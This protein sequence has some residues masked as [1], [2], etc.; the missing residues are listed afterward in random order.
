M[1]KTIDQMVFSYYVA[2]IIY[3]KREGGEIVTKDDYLFM[4]TWALEGVDDERTQKLYKRAIE[5]SRKNV[6]IVAMLKVALEHMFEYDFKDNKSVSSNQVDNK[7]IRNASAI[8]FEKL[9]QVNLLDHT[10]N[11]LEAILQK[12]EEREIYGV[13]QILVA[14]LTHDFGKAK[15]VR[16]LLTPEGVSESSSRYRPH[17]EV[18]GLYVENIL[19]EEAK[20]LLLTKDQNSEISMTIENIAEIVKNHH[21]PAKK[22]KNKIEMVV[23]AD[24]KAREKEL[25]KIDKELGLE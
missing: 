15:K 4:K 14:C 19:G 9:R 5:A 25:K 2:K 18:S 6:K 8:K 11:V 20:R 22:Y 13:G 12:T 1:I 21:N 24:A 10:L 3:D 16:E 7:N 23:L 17:A